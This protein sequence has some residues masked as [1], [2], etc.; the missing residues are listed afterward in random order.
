MPK[1][2]VIIPAYNCASRIPR[3]IN[4]VLSQSF[5]DW[6]LII[7]DDGSSDNTREVVNTFVK[8]DSRIKYF[9]QENSGGPARPKNLG[10]RKS[11][12]E[13]IAFLDHDDEWVSEKLEKQLTYFNNKEN[14]GL[15]ASNALIV[16]EVDGSTLEHTMPK[17]VLP[18]VTLLERN[19]IF[20]SS[21]VIVKRK[22][23]EK[24]GFFDEN[25]KLG[26]DWDMWLRIS[27]Y[28]DFDF[29]YEPLYK[30]Y[31]HTGTVTS[32]L[33]SA[34]KIR[35][36]DY[37]LKK[38]LRLY[39]KYPKQYAYRLLTMGRICYIAGERKKGR[40]LFMRAM[41]ANPFEIRAYVNFFFAV[42]GPKA[43]N[44]FVYLRKKQSSK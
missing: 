38:H 14:I 4:A 28:F 21:G 25:F 15:V 27:I 22:V 40:A 32:N 29:V 26:D 6:E 35:D 24:V 7:I 17:N 33:R 43:Y 13:F 3:T 9:Y 18:I 11:Q 42:L 20:C 12:G 19:L 34:S 37:G 16:N 30:F 23:F 1:V 44:W 39:R 10:L 5:G 2:S 41:L 36:Y 31:R 8:K